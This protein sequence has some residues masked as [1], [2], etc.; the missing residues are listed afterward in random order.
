MAPPPLRI[1]VLTLFPD[2]FEGFVEESIV[3][4][5]I[6]RELV[7]IRRW[8]LR[9]WAS[10]GTSKWTTGRSGEGREWS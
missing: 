10:A 4:R 9:D 5:A 7:A 6:D 3:R 1:D 2:L 8:D